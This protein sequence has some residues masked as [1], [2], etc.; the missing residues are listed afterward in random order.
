MSGDYFTYYANKLHKGCYNITKFVWKKIMKKTYILGTCLLIGM[1]SSS[2]GSSSSEHAEWKEFENKLS[3]LKFVDEYLDSEPHGPADVMWRPWKDAFK[4]AEIKYDGN[5]IKF[6]VLH[7]TAHPTRD[8]V[9]E[10][11][12]QKGLSS[13]FLVDSNGIIVNYVDPFM[14]IA[15]HAG[16]SSFAGYS[17][18]NY[19][20]VG[21]EH[22]GLGYTLTPQCDEYGKPLDGRFIPGSDY[23]WYEFPEA[24]FVASCEL[25]RAL[26]DGFKIPGYNVVTNADITPGRK[27]DIGPMWNYKRAYNEYNVGYFPSETHQIVMQNFHEF[28]EN[29]YLSFIGCFGYDISAPMRALMVNDIDTFDK[30]KQDVIKAYQL[31]YSTSNISG[32]LVEYTKTDILKHVISLA[33]LGKDGYGYFNKEFLRWIKRNLKKASKLAE[34]VPID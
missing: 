25:T 2:F 14:G 29:D 4:R 33:K 9:P 16:T 15:Y 5:N 32:E 19:W 1:A 17:R 24:Q 28:T 31:H 34:Y 6:I 18:L 10:A 11:F 8:T 22:T 12:K 26:Q 20:S 27:S 30:A 3:N 23:Y 13:H 7:Y 21:I